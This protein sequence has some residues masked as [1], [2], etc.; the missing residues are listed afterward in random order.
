M[1]DYLSRWE[2]LSITPPAFCH[3]ISISDDRDDQIQVDESRWASVSFHHFVDAG[4]DED[5]LEIYG[6]DFERHYADYFLAHKADALRR[7]LDELAAASQDIVINC[8]AGR[9]RS[10]AVAMYLNRYHGYSLDKPTPDANLCVYRMLVKEPALMAA[11]QAVTTPVPAKHPLR[12]RRW[13]DSLF[14]T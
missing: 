2:V 6:S 5:V 9:S 7:R 12:I 1:C 3:L 13:W 14:N 8:Q 11:Y 10:A 4:F